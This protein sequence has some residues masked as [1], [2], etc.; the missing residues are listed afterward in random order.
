MK[1]NKKE[2]LEN[3]SIHRLPVG[4]C[5]VPPVYRRHLHLSLRP[6]PS[7]SLVSLGV[8]VSPRPF[9][10]PPLSS[11]R[12]RSESPPQ[13]MVFASS[14]LPA[15]PSRVCASPAPELTLSSPARKEVRLAAARCR[16]THRRGNA[17]ST[18][19]SP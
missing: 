10:K 2:D 7:F 4:H 8:S 12:C 11:H 6:S 14:L 16:G 5:S 13:A 15:P 1:T 3:L 18:P 19:T 17:F 9:Q